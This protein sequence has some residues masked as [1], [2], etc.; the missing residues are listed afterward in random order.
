MVRFDSIKKQIQAILGLDSQDNFSVIV[1]TP[2]T[3]E[4]PE[5]ASY[6]LVRTYDPECGY[7]ASQCSYENGAFWDISDN[8]SS[9]PIDMQNIVSWSYLP[10]DG[11][12]KGI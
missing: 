7:V 11:R 3:E 9:F 2:L 8:G 5:D 4:Y 1:W 6:V 10:D 12:E